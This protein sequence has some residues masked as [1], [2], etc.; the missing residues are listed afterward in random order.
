MPPNIELYIE[1][2]VLHGFKSGDRYRISEAMERRLTQLL[3]M[4]R[5]LSSMENGGEFYRLDGGSF[6]IAAGATPKVVG[7]QIA[8]A[9]HAGIVRTPNRGG[10]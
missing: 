10:K 9:I 5:E 4:S 6:E 7:C 8:E 2:L 3:K 1:K